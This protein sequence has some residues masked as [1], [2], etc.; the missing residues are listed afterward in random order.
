[1]GVDIGHVANGRFAVDP[2]GD[3]EVPG[4][5]PG[6]VH[7]GAVRC[8]CRFAVVPIVVHAGAEVNRARPF[9]ICLRGH[10]DI[11]PPETAFSF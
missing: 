8:Q 4:T 11:I 7:H 3:H 1:M 10:P 6:E 5:A 9:V 2:A